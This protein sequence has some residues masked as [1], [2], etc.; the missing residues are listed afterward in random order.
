[1]CSA[2]CTLRL[3]RV[4]RRRNLIF[5]A[6]LGA[7]PTFLGRR[8]ARPTVVAAG[9]VFAVAG[10]AF[11]DG[12]DVGGG[13]EDATVVFHRD[14]ELLGEDFLGKDA[15]TAARRDD[16]GADGGQVALEVFVDVVFVAEAALQA[17]AAARDF[18]RVER[19]LLHFGHLHRDGRHFA[20][21]GAAANRLAA[22]AVVGQQLG[23]VA[24]ADLPHFNAR[25]KL[26]GEGFDQIAKINAL[27]TDVIDDQPFTAKDALDIDE[28]HRQF[29]AFDVLDADVEAGDLA[30]LNV[31]QLVL[32]F[33]RHLA[34]DLP[35]GSTGEQLG[36]LVGGF[37]ENFGRF[38][39]AG[40][41]SDDARAAQVAILAARR[42]EADGASGAVAEDVAGHGRKRSEVRRQRSD[43]VS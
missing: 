37:G 3:G 19:G 34:H 14:E 12:E 32:V 27:F 28:L 39:A 1:L 10:A 8:P 17:A 21:E 18:G 26:G 15:S 36:L 33:G 40:R 29:E 22:I 9:A 6:R 23:F 41:A 20:E 25:L 42:E 5:L 24:D 35:A 38:Q 2:Y 16:V 13:D 30:L 7:C 11:E 4:G 31:R 43:L